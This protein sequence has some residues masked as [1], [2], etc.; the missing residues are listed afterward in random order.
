VRRLVREALG[1]ERHEVTE[2]ADGKEAL[3]L[4]R[5]HQPDVVVL[6]LVMPELDGFS[7][8]EQIQADPETRFLPVVV[9]TGKELTDEERTFL[10]FRAFSVLQKSSASPGELRRRVGEA[11]ARASGQ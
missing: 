11:L 4:I 7:V 10:R 2:A 3:A 9:L 6:D 1:A 5:A 8:L